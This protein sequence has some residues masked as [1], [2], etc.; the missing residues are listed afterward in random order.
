MAAQENSAQGV[1]SLCH[2]A[3]FWAR[4]LPCR[5]NGETLLDLSEKTLSIDFHI[6]FWRPAVSSFVA[7]FA[8]GCMCTIN[9]IIQKKHIHVYLPITWSPIS[10]SLLVSS[11]LVSLQH[12]Q[13]CEIHSVC[14][15][16]YSL[17]SPLTCMFPETRVLVPLITSTSPQSSAISLA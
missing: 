9:Y 8:W 13:I 2:K 11:S 6:L 17:F 5:F 7:K 15:C 16:L 1:I 14:Y 10:S 12:F 4:A 3:L